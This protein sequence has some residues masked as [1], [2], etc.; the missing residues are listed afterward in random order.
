MK[1]RTFLTGVTAS[2]VCAAHGE[3]QRS[4]TDLRDPIP[5]GL[6]PPKRKV[7]RSKVATL[8]IEDPESIKILQFT[9]V[10]FFCNRDQFGEHAD[11]RTIDDL[12]RITE[13]TNPDLIAFTG[14]VWHDPPK[15]EGAARLEFAVNAMSELGK[16]WLFTWGNHDLLDDY[17]EAQAILTEAPHSLY[18]GGHDGG[19]Y[20]VEFQR[21]T[22][23]LS[24]DLLCLNTTTQGIQSA[25]EDWLRQCQS[26]KRPDRKALCFLHIPVLQYEE[27]WQ[28]K[29][30]RGFQKEAV[31]TYGEDGS[32]FPLLGQLGVKA[33]FCGHDHVNDYGGRIEG[34]DCVYGRASGHAGYGGDDVK[35]GGKLITLNERN[36]TYQW[37][38]VFADGSSWTP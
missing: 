4:P 20:R 1:R 3:G 37:A 9:D 18:R 27:V 8:K 5:I 34:I 17:A 22:D 12:K 35:K 29:R 6:A 24:W 19:N 10:H 25:Q 11:R 16:P 2:A 28:S 26:L 36:D 32:A 38:T 31:C 13:Q 15:G 7:S 14:D 30:A 23:V 33:C 21:E